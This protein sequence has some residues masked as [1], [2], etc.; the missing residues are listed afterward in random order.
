MMRHAWMKL[1][2]V[3]VAAMVSACG[4]GVEAQEQ[5]PGV[6]VSQGL[7]DVSLSE[8]A[9]TA[10]LQATLNT[11]NAKY[12]YTD[13]SLRRFDFTGTATVAQA[14]AAVL[15]LQEYS[16]YA[17]PAAQNIS[18]A[19]F[20]NTL[21]LEFQ[22]LHSQILSTYQ[23]GG[24]SVQVVTH[25]YEDLVAAGSTGWFRLTVIFFPVSKKVIVFEQTAYEV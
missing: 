22:P 13:G 23:T 9:I 1:G 16:Q 20:K 14:D 21:Y 18:Y 19:D 10:A 24:E 3:V 11:G 12:F 25:Y 15:S 6:E 17:R 2:S 4:A 7:A 5:A 8:K